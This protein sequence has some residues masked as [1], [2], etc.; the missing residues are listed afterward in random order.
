MDQCITII[1]TIFLQAQR[2]QNQEDIYPYINISKDIQLTF[3]F[4]LCRSPTEFT[5]VLGPRMIRVLW[6]HC[7]QT[8]VCSPSRIFRMF[9]AP[10]T[11]MRGLPKRW[12][13]KT[14]PCFSRLEMW[15]LEPCHNITEFDQDYSDFCD[16]KVVYTRFILHTLKQINQ[17]CNCAWN[18]SE[19]YVLLHEELHPHQVNTCQ[20]IMCFSMVEELVHMFNSSLLV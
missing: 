11:R 7:V 19:M 17:F 10:V 3:L 20:R 13:L 16:R 18:Q 15:K 8:T 1:L 12:V 9:S 4:L 14:F 2:H 6:G 5:K